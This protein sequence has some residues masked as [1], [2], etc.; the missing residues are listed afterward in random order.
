MARGIGGDDGPSVFMFAACV[1]IFFKL[2][3]WAKA[4]KDAVSAELDTN[5]ASPFQSQT[6]SEIKKMEKYVAGITYRSS[7][8]KKPAATYVSIAN[9]CWKELS[10]DWYVSDRKLFDLLDPLNADELK[11]VAKAFGV[12]E[13]TALGITSGTYTIFTAF[14]EVLED[15]YVFKDLAKMHLIWKKTGLW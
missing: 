1:L 5:H 4:G 15:G 3:D 13:S 2:S 11:A 9:Q 8:L 7:N 12:K 10:A 14:D 6:T